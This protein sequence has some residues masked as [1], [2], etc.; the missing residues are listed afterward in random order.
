[1]RTSI[2]HV[3]P[4]LIA[5][6]V[7]SLVGCDSE[8]APPTS[9]EGPAK[10]SATQQQN[11]VADDNRPKFDPSHPIAKIETSMGDIVIQLDAEKAPI[12]VKNFLWYASSGHYDDMIFH[13]VIDGYIALAGGYTVNLIEKPTYF[14]IHNEAYNRLKNKKYTLAM[15]R[16]ADQIDSSTSQFFFNLDDNDQLNHKSRESAEDF[17]YCVFG[18]VISGQDVLHR[19]SKVTVQ[20]TEKLASVPVQPIMVKTVTQTD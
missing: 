17:G 11:E 20:D 14:P 2:A 3:T 18:K 8:Q 7:L 19:I 10:Q 15:A 1:M 16:V 5:F 12:T 9:L 6:F 13:Q 4:Y